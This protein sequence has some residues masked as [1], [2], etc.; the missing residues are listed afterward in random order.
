L[1]VFSPDGSGI[2]YF[3]FKKDRSTAG[4]ML[5]KMHQS[6]AL[7]KKYCQEKV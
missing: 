4:G 5:M 3:F 1:F 7:K 6:S 2:L